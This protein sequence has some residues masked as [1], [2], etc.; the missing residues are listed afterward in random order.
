MERYQSIFCECVCL[1][2]LMSVLLM[3]VVAKGAQAAGDK[4]FQISGGFFQNQGD[5]WTGTASGQVSLGYYFSPKWQV[6]A[7]QLGSYSLNNDIEDVWTAS[8][9]AFVHR[10][11]WVDKDDGR[12]QPFLGAFAGLAYSDV[13]VTGT[14][15][16]TLG[17]R[18]FVNNTTFLVTQYRYEFYF[19]ELDAGDETDDFTDGTH[20]LTVG[21]GVIW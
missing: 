9:T 5:A 18:Y 20:T 19:S 1:L 14:A 15:G 6:G 17:V 7:R 13:D 3:P 11:F 12:L 4:E 2:V 8:T 21:F 16:P 10:Y